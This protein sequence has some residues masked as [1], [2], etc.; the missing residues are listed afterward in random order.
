MKITVLG[1]GT[2]FPSASRGPTGLLLQVG[3]HNYLIDGGSG[4]LQKLAIAGIDPVQLDGGFYSHWHPDHCGDLVPLLFAMRV[5]QVNRPP[6]PIFAREGFE[7]FYRKLQDVYGKWID[8]GTHGIEIREW[9][10]SGHG[11]ATLGELQVTVAPAVHSAGAV[12]LRFDANHTSIVFSG[13]TGPSDSLAVL[14]TGADLLIV[15][16]ASPDHQPLGGHMTPSAICSL[17]QRSQPKEIWLTHLYPNVDE[18][19]ALHTVRASGVP[20][21]LVSDGMSWTGSSAA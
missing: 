7:T 2:A 12:H 20:T 15:E 17:A 1:S 3:T 13:D 8:P 11:S 14:A 21:L 19:T 10:S 6:Y 9:P 18:A 5:A 16:C 4:T